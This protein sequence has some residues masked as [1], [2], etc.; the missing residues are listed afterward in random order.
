M[1]DFF[2]NHTRKHIVRAEVDAMFNVTKNLRAVFARYRW[3]IEDHIEFT[4]S[5]SISHRRGRT[6]L[7]EEKYLLEN[8]IADVHHFL[9][10]DSREYKDITL[11]EYVGPFG[12]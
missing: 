10:K 11:V 3:S 12:V 8:W 9:N 2:I 6:L 5:E 7:I 4:S 1:T